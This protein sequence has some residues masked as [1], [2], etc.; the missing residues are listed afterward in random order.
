M[1]VVNARF[2]TQHITGVQRFAIE[3]SLRLKDLL[4]DEVVFVA[5]KDILLEDYAKLLNVQRIGK[6]HGHLWEQ[7]E[8]PLYLKRHGSPLLVCLCNTA[9]L[10]YRNKVVT[11]H[12]VAFYV[13]PKMF[14]KSFLTVYRFMIP[15][16]LKSARHV[17]TVS[18]FSKQE[19][20]KFCG[21]N[22]N[23]ISVIYNAVSG[24]FRYIKDDELAKH[25]YFLAVS[26]LNYRKNFPAVLDAFKKFEEHNDDGSLYIIGDMSNSSF[27]ALDID[28]YKSDPRIKFLGRV[29]DKDLVRYY[30]N[31]VAFIYPSLYEGF[32]IPPLEAQQCNCPVISSNA[33]SLPEV[34]GDSALFNSPNDID[35]FTSRMQRIFNEENL[36]EQL[37][38]KGLEN[39]KRFSWDKS[40]R[41]LINIIK[42]H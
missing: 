5:P 40:T 7:I 20:I 4:K 8:L 26:S 14:S 25:K 32:G 2:L 12:D 17:I 1:I 21:T 15:R 35:G 31:A 3:I 18:E 22:V 37:I 42:S 29:S 28:I 13:F 30:S 16:I 39:I 36:R 38:Q 24:D 11:L 27:A 6:L 23:K 19:I 10:Y 41:E 9:P 33:T 34:L